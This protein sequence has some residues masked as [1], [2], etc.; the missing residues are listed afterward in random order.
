MREFGPEGYDPVWDDNRDGM[1]YDIDG[2][3]V[4]MRQWV[5]AFESRQNRHIAK[6]T[7]PDGTF[8]STVHLGINHGFG[9]RPIIFETMVFLPSGESDEMD[10]YSTKEEAMEGHKRMVEKWK[11]K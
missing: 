3:P 1:Y 4:S 8:I 9:N 10:R 6:D 7:L 2:N 5:N 11:S